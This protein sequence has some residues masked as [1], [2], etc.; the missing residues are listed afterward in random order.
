[1]VGGRGAPASPC[2][3]RRVTKSPCRSWLGLPLHKTNPAV[4]RSRSHPAQELFISCRE[5]PQSQPRGPGNLQTALAIV[6]G[7]GL[8]WAS[9]AIPLDRH[10]SEASKASCP[11]SRLPRGC[12][13]L[14]PCRDRWAK[15]EPLPPS[16]GPVSGDLSP[17][18]WPGVPGAPQLG[19]VH[20]WPGLREVFAVPW[21]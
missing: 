6:S 20:P 16:P 8:P 14:Q 21:W 1:M 18:G 7:A 9:C 12:S 19:C 13:S 2:R 3:Q 11:E 5:E 17:P 4:N 10:H 15:A